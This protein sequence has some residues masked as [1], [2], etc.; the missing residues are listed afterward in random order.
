M[1]RARLMQ[2]VRDG[3][4]SQDGLVGAEGLH[5]VGEVRVRRR[6][7]DHCIHVRQCVS[8]LEGFKN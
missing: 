6:G 8:Q 5:D 4:L 3:L 7:D 2:L 1:R